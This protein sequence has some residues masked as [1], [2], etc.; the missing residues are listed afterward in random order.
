MRKC[1]IETGR[2][3]PAA[4][5]EGYEHL[6]RLTVRVETDGVSP[7][8]LDDFKRRVPGEDRYWGGNEERAD[9]KDFAWY[10]APRHLPT[11]AAWA[12]KWYKAAAYLK[13]GQ[14]ETNLHSW[15]S[16]ETPDLFAPVEEAVA[17]I[18]AVMLDDVPVGGLVNFD[19]LLQAATAAVRAGLTGEFY[20]GGPDGQT[21]SCDLPSATF[22]LHDPVRMLY[23]RVE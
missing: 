22:A 4:G 18:R 7:D 15:R 12:R 14:R 6:T 8:A 9:L 11:V 2:A 5:G 16:T 20:M 3:A 23:R 1:N 21:H 19:A 13:C 10:V 17:A